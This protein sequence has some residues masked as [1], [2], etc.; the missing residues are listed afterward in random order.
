LKIRLEE[1]N[2]DIADVAGGDES[3]EFVIIISH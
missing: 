1:I 3:D 2:D